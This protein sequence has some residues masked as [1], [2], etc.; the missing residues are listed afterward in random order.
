[1]HA[2]NQT[3]RAGATCR[4]IYLVA[5]QRLQLQRAFSL[6]QQQ[7]ANTFVIELRVMLGQLAYAQPVF[8]L[9]IDGAAK[10]RAGDT[11]LVV[12]LV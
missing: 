5:C 8:G 6:L 7:G 9:S 10:G 12:Q 3:H 1:M 2:S 11:N 4:G